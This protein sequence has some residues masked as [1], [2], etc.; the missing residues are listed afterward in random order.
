M[1][2]VITCQHRLSAERGISLH[3]TVIGF[4]PGSFNLLFHFPKAQLWRAICH[5]CQP[6]G[7]GQCVE[8]QRTAIKPWKANF[9]FTAGKFIN[10]YYILTMYN[11]FCT[12][13]DLRGGSGSIMKRNI[14][15]ERT[16]EMRGGLLKAKDYP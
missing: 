12:Q 2:F 11:T 4:L 15:R 13:T 1:Y 5:G 8:R 7:G 16:K 3:K 10:I 6:P 9:V 14:T